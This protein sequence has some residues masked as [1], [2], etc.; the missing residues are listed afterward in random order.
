M[1][2]GSVREI[3]LKKRLPRIILPILLATGVLI[4]I[5]GC[6]V[7]T[8]SQIKEVKNFT[9][10]SKD[11]TELPGALAESYG[12]L[13]RNNKLLSVSRY[14]YGKVDESGGVDTHNSI[15]AWQELKEAY[16]LEVDFQE[17]G[18]RMNTALEILKEYSAI[19]SALVSDDYTN[20]LGESATKVGNSLD[21]TVDRYNKNYSSGKPLPKVGGSIGMII[22]AVGGIYIRHKQAEIL[23]DTIGKAN[24]LIEDLMDEVEMIASKNFKSDLSNYETNYLESSFISVANNLKRLDFTSLALV[25]EDL[26]RVRT[27]IKLADQVAQAART[28]KKAHAQLVNNTRQPLELKIIIEEIQALKKEVETAQKVKKNIEG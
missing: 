24:P 26:K 18:Q 19:L 10:A 21:D 8:E 23:R 17:T 9:N 1:K 15:K 4:W 2:D 13:L 11:Y 6:A 25:Y 16:K 7:L 3:S 12:V 28:Y 22:R 20:A 27:T 5:N 14:E